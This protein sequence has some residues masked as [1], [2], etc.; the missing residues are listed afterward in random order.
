M[1]SCLSLLF[2]QYTS[3]LIGF[4]TCFPMEVNPKNSAKIRDNFV[5]FLQLL[6]YL[7]TLQTLLKQVRE[8]DDKKKEDEK[9][10]KTNKK[11]KVKKKKRS[12]KK[13]DIKAVVEKETME[14]I[15]SC[16][17]KAVQVYHTRTCANTYT[18]A[19]IPKSYHHTHSLTLTFTLTLTLTTHTLT[20]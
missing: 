12:K 8:E 2:G 4:K 5:S 19:H 17:R 13:V 9:E 1:T 10:E 3:R 7:I 11:E 14:F 18:H 20:G 15:C 16:L 6:H